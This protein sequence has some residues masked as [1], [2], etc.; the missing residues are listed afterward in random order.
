MSFLF[1]LFFCLLVKVKIIFLDKMLLTGSVADINIIKNEQGAKNLTV[2]F[3][4]KD[5]SVSKQQKGIYRTSL[6]V[7][8]TTA[9]ENLKKHRWSSLRIPKEYDRKT[10]FIGL[11][12]S[13]GKIECK[14][15]NPKL[16][17]PS[18]QLKKEVFFTIFFAIF[19]I[20]FSGYYSNYNF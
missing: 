12:G 6:I 1:F 3:R 11:H 9:C 17:S 7:E 14:I 5:T 4:K 15:P 20:L 16:Q 19:L 2:S 18:P 13:N 8:S 10:S